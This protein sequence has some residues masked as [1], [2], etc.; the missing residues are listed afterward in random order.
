MQHIISIGDTKISNKL[1]FVLIG[2]PCQ[3]E[4]LDHSLFMAENLVK[5]T[6]KLG[7]S[8]IYKSS[9]DKANRTSAT[10]KR[11]VGLEKSLEIFKAI[12]DKFGCPV[13][14]DVHKEE[15]C[16]IMAEVVDIY[17]YQHFCVDKLTFWQQQ[18]KQEK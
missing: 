14:T 6:K 13:I 10:A 8:F 11:G 12:K 7:I 9:F 3:I 15:Q 5:I 2:G 17:K 4:S 18:L 16:D 1:P